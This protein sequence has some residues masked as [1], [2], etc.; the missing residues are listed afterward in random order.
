[1]VK[2]QDPSQTLSNQTTAKQLY[3]YI[4]VGIT[5]NAA[6]YCV[7]LLV[8]Y[9]GLAPKFAMTILYLLGALMGFF[10]NSALTFSYQGGKMGAGVR[11]MLTHF[12]GYLINLSILIIFVDKVGYPHQLVQAIAVFIVAAFLFIAFKLFVFKTTDAP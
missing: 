2:R 9:F 6:G 5:T 12:T 10:G 8:T 4:L 7:Y 1:M 3:R 11:Y